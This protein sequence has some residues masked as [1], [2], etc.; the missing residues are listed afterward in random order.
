[1]ATETQ[2]K[3]DIVLDVKKPHL[4]WIE[5]ILTLYRSALINSNGKYKIISERA[6]LPIRH[7]FHSG[8]MMAGKMSIK[9][10]SNPLKNNQITA[11]FVNR[12]MNWNRDIYILEDSASL[13]AGDLTKPADISLLGLTRKSEVARRADI[14]LQDRRAKRREFT[15]QTGLDAI[16]A[17]VGD[18]AMV[19]LTM[20]DWE[21]GYGGRVLDGSTTAF[22]ADREVHLNSG[23]VYELYVSHVAA[24][25]VEQRLVVGSTTQIQ[26]VPT[27]PFLF[28]AIAPDRWVLGV[29]SEDLVRCQIKKITFNPDEGVHEIVAEEFLNLQFKLNCPSSTALGASDARPSYPTT[30]TAAFSNCQVCFGLTYASC[31]GGITSGPSSI[32][33]SIILAH[34]IHSLRDGQ[35]YGNTLSIL[36]GT[37][38]GKST[39]ISQWYAGSDR[40]HYAPYAGMTDIESGATYRIAFA[41]G[42]F[43]SGFR[44]DVS[45]NAGSFSTLEQFF[46][47][48]GCITFSGVNTM[49]LARVIPVSPFGVTPLNLGTWVFSLA[50]AGCFSV[51]DGVITQPTT[52]AVQSLANLF[53][54]NIPT[55]LFTVSNPVNIV[56]K[57]FINENC[58]SSEVTHASFGLTLAG[59]TVVDSLVIALRKSESTIAIGSNYLFDLK[60]SFNVF[61]SPQTHVRAAL[62]YDGPAFDQTIVGTERASGQINGVNPDIANPVAMTVKLFHTDTVGAVHS[63]GCFSV[64]L[65]HAEFN[66]G[67]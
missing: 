29:Q 9:I 4:T 35:L 55:S 30:V 11:D 40:S 51:D 62:R 41:V 3:L 59:S 5:D 15:F 49:T 58:V 2:H 10:A 32:N 8:N 17:E 57:G 34:S 60:A 45:T 38:S 37:N 52:I 50:T 25:T 6:D 21:A 28:P 53:A 14:D 31:Q 18:F 44:V 26:I 20:T 47:D 56:A 24:D 39:W 54:F 65:D 23:T 42:S 48:S 1:M 67:A 16:A 33:L 64:V 46:A 61:T 36:S 13:L 66:S 19:G 27:S 12:D 63:H 43:V 22:F 7:V